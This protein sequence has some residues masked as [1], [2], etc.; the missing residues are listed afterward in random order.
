MEIS[1]MSEATTILF[2]SRFYLALFFLSAASGKIRNPRRFVEGVI[3][4]QV[5]PLKVARIWGFA[6]PWIELGVALALVVGIALPLAGFVALMLLFS[7][8]IAVGLNLQRGRRISCNCHGTEGTNTISWGTIARNVLLLLYSAAVIGTSL[9][10][11]KSVNWLPV[12]DTNRLIVSPLELI[13]LLVP[14]FMFCFVT[15]N[16]VEWA[17]DVYDRVSLLKSRLNHY[18][19][20]V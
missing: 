14:L 1:R 10:T 12:S 4:Y 20:S 6:L 15:T 3:E 8:I 13:G 18:R 19:R 5:L 2:V 11:N 16:L 7:F 9:F 17:V